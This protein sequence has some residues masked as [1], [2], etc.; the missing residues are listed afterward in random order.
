MMPDDLRLAHERLDA[1]V[2]AAYGVD[3]GGDEYKIVVHLFELYLAATA[4]A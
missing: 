2:E 3:F 1:A 4:K